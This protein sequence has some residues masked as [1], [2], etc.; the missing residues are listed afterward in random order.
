[1]ES[2]REASLRA[3]AGEHGTCME[4]ICRLT[5]QLKAAEEASLRCK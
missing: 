3:S 5:L 4:A 1:M 2:A